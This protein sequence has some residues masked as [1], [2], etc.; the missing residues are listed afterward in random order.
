MADLAILMVQWG[1]TALL[2]VYA[3]MVWIIP[4]TRNKSVGEQLRPLLFVHAFRFV[5]LMMFQPGQLPESFPPELI[6]LIAWGDFAAALAA[7][8]ALLIWHVAPRLGRI[9]TWAFSLIGTADMLL[10]LVEATR[11]QVWT[12]P[13]GFIYT[14]PVFYVPVLVVFQGLIFVTLLQKGQRT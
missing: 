2:A 1:L 12:I 14:I 8:L 7:M 3:S 6:R 11:A 10:V 9:A 5:P 13:L 4:A